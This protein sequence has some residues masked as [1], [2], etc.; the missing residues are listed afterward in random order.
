M[1]LDALI[2]VILLTARNDDSILNQL[3]T[4]LTHQL[5]RWLVVFR[6]LPV[7]CLLL[8]L[9][10]YLL[11]SHCSSV[12]LCVCVRER[13]TVGQLLQTHAWRGGLEMARM[14]GRM[15][16]DE[17]SESEVGR[18]KER[19]KRRREDKRDGKIQQM[20]ES[21]CGAW[22]K[23]ISNFQCEATWSP[24]TLQTHPS[25]MK[26]LITCLRTSSNP[27]KNTASEKIHIRSYN[28]RFSYMGF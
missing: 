2:A 28:L 23:L 25:L 10:P 3:L 9:L 8:F 6:E 24:C 7:R 4:D 26:M 21:E 22:K 14:V 17:K 12:C 20:E 18:T 16:E 11:I 5:R 15:D 27:H 19:G 1:N 13:K